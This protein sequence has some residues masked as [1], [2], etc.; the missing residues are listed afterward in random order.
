MSKKVNQQLAAYRPIPISAA[1]DIA[2][3]YG[4]Q[5]VIIVTWDAVHGLTHVTTYGD[6]VEA[7]VQAAE[8]GNRVKAALG[9]PPEECQ[10]KP[11]RRSRGRK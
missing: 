11:R 6:T 7:C 1:R 8:G 10:A 2:E 4:K 5:Q 3:E 9:W